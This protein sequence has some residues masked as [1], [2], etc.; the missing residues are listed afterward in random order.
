MATL[1]ATQALARLRRMIRADAAPLLTTD[2]VTDLFLMV[3]QITDAD[4]VEPDGVGYVPT[5]SPYAAA[6]REAAATGWEW[7]AGQVAGE[8]TVA[9]GTGTKFERE[10]QHRMCLEMAATF[11]G[12]ARRPGG[13]VIG[14]IL[15]STPSTISEDD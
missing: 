9:T 5:Y 14:S 8:Y 6:F 11:G 4:G 10:G 3:P 12:G 15:V 13:G 2:D 7:K 1:D